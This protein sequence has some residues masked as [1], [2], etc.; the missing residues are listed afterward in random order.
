MIVLACV[1]AA[2]VA[3]LF[4]SWLSWRAYA[5]VSMENRDLLKV[6][7]A[8]SQKDTAGQLAGFMEQTDSRD[9]GVQE[10]GARAPHRRPAGV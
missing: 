5:R 9:L 8:L 1:G 10:N 2:L 3:F 6:V 7:C 4:S